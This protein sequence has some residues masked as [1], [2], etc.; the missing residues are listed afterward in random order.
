MATCHALFSRI[1]AGIRAQEGFSDCV[2]VCVCGRGGRVV[3][4]GQRLAGSKDPT[5]PTSWFSLAPRQFSLLPG[6]VWFGTL[7]AAPRLADMDSQ[8]CP[9]IESV[10]GRDRT[11]QLEDCWRAWAP[12]AGSADQCWPGS[13]CQLPHPTLCPLSVGWKKGMDKLYL[14]LMFLVLTV[15]LPA[16]SAPAWNLPLTPKPRTPY[17]DCSY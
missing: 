8:M 3:R 1:Q 12:K 10:P 14:P 4:I 17:W 5:P 13:R 9:A 11:A 6:W 7:W 15:L 2:P 16:A